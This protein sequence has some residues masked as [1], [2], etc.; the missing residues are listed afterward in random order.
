MKLSEAQISFLAHR[1]ID[2]IRAAGARIANDRI[3]LNEAKALIERVLS[4]SAG[5]HQRVARKIA[6]LSRRV[7]EGSPEY[8]I[9]YR[10]YTEEEM[11]RGR[12]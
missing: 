11:R 8:E 6:S 12:R 5:V 2:A 10:Q 4:E 3:A 7:P 9:L 1:S